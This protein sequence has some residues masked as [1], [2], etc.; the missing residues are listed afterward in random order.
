MTLLKKVYCFNS[1]SDYN[2]IYYLV[3]KINYI[4]KIH[5]YF[6]TGSGSNGK[7]KITE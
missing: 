6:W 2:L 5:F 1:L 3:V 4:E 7:S